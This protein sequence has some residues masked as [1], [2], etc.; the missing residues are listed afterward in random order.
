MLNNQ[1]SLFSLPEDIHYLNCAY[2]GPQLKTVEQAGIAAI[3]KK[4]NPI[5]IKPDHFFEEAEALRKA[6]GQL[7][8][9]NPK[10]VAII[11]SASYGMMAAVNNLPLN[12]GNT[13]IVVGE[14]FPSG[15]FSIARWCDE[16][17][18]TLQV[19]KR[20]SE[21]GVVGR[22]WNEQVLES[23]NQDTA[24]VL[25]S[26]VHWTDGTRFLLEEIGQ[27][28]K[29]NG[30]YFILDGTQSVGAI[31]IDVQAVKADALICAGYKWLL[32]PYAIGL[33]YYAD[34][35]NDGRPL[36]ESWMNRSN[37]TDFSGLTN[38][39]HDYSAGAGRYN[40]GEF[41]NFVLLPMLHTAIQQI[42]DW[43]EGTI[44]AYVKNLAIPLRPFFESHGYGIE[45]ENF[46]SPHLFG[47]H[48]PKDLDK[49][50][51][52]KKLEDRKIYVSVRGEAIRLSLHLYNTSEDLESLMDVLDR[53]SK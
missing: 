38:Y 6:F 29:E 42:L 46:R 3:Q 11:P 39:A 33:A 25:M 13:A 52:L 9:A 22:I 53:P 19:I 16:K 8:N 48:L 12:N 1:K 14:E 30:A 24:V 7:V 43:G 10:Q 49:T 36:E 32:G 23:I 47:I 31:P 17:G 50:T 2:M 20:P 41:S 37:S 21:R 18:K 4:N 51:L 15:Y 45:E 35:F 5:Q 40:M 34:N 44:Q 27:K 28:C 26:T